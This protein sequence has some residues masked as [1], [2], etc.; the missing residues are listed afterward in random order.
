MFTSL[1]LYQFFL[2]KQYIT[3]NLQWIPT[4][5]IGFQTPQ[6]MCDMH[7]SCSKAYFILKN[8]RCHP[9]KS[10]WRSNLKL[11][12]HTQGGDNLH[13]HTLRLDLLATHKNQNYSSI[14]GVMPQIYRNTGGVSHCTDMVLISKTISDFWEYRGDNSLKLYKNHATFDEYSCP[15]IDIGGITPWLNY[16]PIA[17][18]IQV[19]NP[20]KSYDDTCINLRWDVV[21]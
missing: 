2:E 11:S 17:M 3:L 7:P 13:C 8:P 9:S 15:L 10:K 16:Y 12:P 18:I 5:W 6:S 21:S 19:D 20:G 14:L 1:K 4:F